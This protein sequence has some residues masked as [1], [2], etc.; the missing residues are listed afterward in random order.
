[1]RSLVFATAISVALVGVAS[2]SSPGPSGYFQTGSHVHR[3][4]GAH[5]FT[6]VHDIKELPAQR[7]AG[8][9]VEADVEK[10]FVVYVLGDVPCSTLT[11]MLEAGAIREGMSGATAAGIVHAC[12]S[13]SLK[14]GTRAV[15]AYDPATKTTSISAEGRGTASFQGLPAM[16][17]I[18]GVWLGAGAPAGARGDLSSRM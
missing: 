13:G 3:T 8:A 12:P 7:T 6:V 5:D 10:R 1:M 17:Q 14:R 16:R 9:L 2:A 4:G 15:V 18:W 11:N